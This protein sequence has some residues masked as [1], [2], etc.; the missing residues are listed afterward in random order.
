MFKNVTTLCFTI[1]LMSVDTWCGGNEKNTQT[2]VTSQSQQNREQTQCSDCRLQQ[3][4]HV[5]PWL[6]ITINRIAVGLYGKWTWYIFYFDSLNNLASHFHWTLGL[7]INFS[8]QLTLTL[9]KLYCLLRLLFL[10]SSYY[11]CLSVTI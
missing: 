5:Y 6:N 9:A 8:H 2:H 10:S 4:L 11:I 3:N 1:K 7:V